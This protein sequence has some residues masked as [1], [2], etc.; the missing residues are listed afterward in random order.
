MSASHVPELEWPEG[1]AARDGAHV[2]AA[3]LAVLREPCGID[4]CAPGMVLVLA[5]DPPAS[6]SSDAEIRA[7]A[8]DSTG[9]TIPTETDL[10][11]FSW[12]KRGLAYR[13]ASPAL[14]AP[15]IAT[16]LAMGSTTLR[17]LAVPNGTGRSVEELGDLIVRFGDDALAA[18]PTPYAG[19]LF[20]T[21]VLIAFEHDH[22]DGSRSAAHRLR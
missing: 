17:L 5:P 20:D 8:A 9:G 6:A 10:E 14:F 21:G 18:A 22:V 1:L 15:L 12:G 13:S 16:F 7:A 2:V 3:V 4:V 11:R 19:L